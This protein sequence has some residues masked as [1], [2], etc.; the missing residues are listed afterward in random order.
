MNSD[1]AGCR[2]LAYAHDNCRNRDVRLYLI[3]GEWEA[4][5]VTDGVDKWVA[6]AVRDIMSVDIPKLLRMLQAGDDIPKP[7]PLVRR[8]REALVVEEEPQPKKRP[9]VVIEDQPQPRRSRVQLV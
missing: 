5:G 2:L 8:Q 3:P 4:V 7:T 9:R 6:P 1:F